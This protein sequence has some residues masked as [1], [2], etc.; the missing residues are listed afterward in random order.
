[1]RTWRKCGIEAVPIL[2]GASGGYT[3]STLFA[4]IEE[5]SAL[6]SLMG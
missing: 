3:I 1:M 2:V 6:R 4:L 5:H